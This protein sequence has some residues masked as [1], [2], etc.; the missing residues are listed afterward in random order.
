MNVSIEETVRI[1]HI[2]QDH[3]HELAIKFVQGLRTYREAII[4]LKKPSDLATLWTSGELDCY[5]RSMEYELA[6]QLL[7]ESIDRSNHRT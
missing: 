5:E 4:E 6:M 2:G 3:S 7:R 1:G